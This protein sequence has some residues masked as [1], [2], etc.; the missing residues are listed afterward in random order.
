MGGSS[1]NGMNARPSPGA[2]TAPGGWRAYGLRFLAVFA[3]VY[4]PGLL[5][6]RWFGAG[7]ACLLSALAAGA[8][9]FAAR[10][11]LPPGGLPR[12]AMGAVAALA[13]MAVACGSVLVLWL[14]LMA[15]AVSGSPY[16][17]PQVNYAWVFGRALALS[18]LTT[19]ATQALLCRALARQSPG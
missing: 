5:V 8:G 4:G 12:S 9:W 19:F 2:A 18:W 16:D 11:A 7:G 6:T 17:V 10:R 15:V 3:V 14:L 13:A 1:V